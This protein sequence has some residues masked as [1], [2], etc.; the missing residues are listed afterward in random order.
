MTTATAMLASEVCGVPPALIPMTLALEWVAENK[1]V[2][3]LTWP[4]VWLFERML[5]HATGANV[6]KNK[7]EFDHELH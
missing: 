2:G 4:G 7:S 3:H 6:D 5:E 1:A